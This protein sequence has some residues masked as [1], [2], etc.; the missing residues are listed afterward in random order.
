MSEY[1]QEQIRQ[2]IIK[3]IRDYHWSEDFTIADI[4]KRFELDEVSAR[5]IVSD[6][7][8]EDGLDVDKDSHGQRR[9]SLEDDN[10]SV[11]CLFSVIMATVIAVVYVLANSDID[12]SDPIDA[13]Y[14]MM[15]IVPA[16]I[17]LISVVVI[18]LIYRLS[19]SPT[20]SRIIRKI[21]EEGFECQKV[22]GMIVFK[23]RGINWWIHTKDVSKRYRRTYFFLGVNLN[24]LS[25]HRETINALVCWI[26]HNKSHVNL[27][28]DGQSEFY[29][30]Y[31]TVLTKTSDITR[32]FSM[33]VR[34]IDEAACELFE[35]LDTMAQGLSEKQES[36]ERKIGFK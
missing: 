16:I 3:G 15:P 29:F 22:E 24:D 7:L 8:N 27:T 25:E 34:V 4:M 36:Q 5:K 26:G 19:T 33:A 9:K 1:N 14:S 20:D 30:C 28:W 2:Y 6:I 35:R 11:G 32:E 23:H 10:G 21:K 17:V 12:L 31:E 18:N 13:F